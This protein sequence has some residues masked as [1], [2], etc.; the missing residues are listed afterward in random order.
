MSIFTTRPCVHFLVNPKASARR[1]WLY[2]VLI[3][4]GLTLFCL[5]HW[6]EISIALLLN[7]NRFQ[8]TI[9][10]KIY[11][12]ILRLNWIYAKNLKLMNSWDCKWLLRS[13]VY[14]EPIL[15][16]R[17][18]VVIFKNNRCISCMLYVNLCSK[19][20]NCFPI[21]IKIFLN[22]PLCYSLD[23]KWF[24]KNKPIVGTYTCS[25]YWGFLF[26]KN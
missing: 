20:Q 3:S 15:Y 14:W 19:G 6:T 16:F 1:T 26:K 23:K 12:F 2:L 13:L 7:I 22:I 18:D 8:T 10:I 25:I 21:F 9:I 17:K 5:I 24:C 4:F 11:Q